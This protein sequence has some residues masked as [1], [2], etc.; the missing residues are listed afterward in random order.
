[1]STIAR[2]SNRQHE[3]TCAAVPE[4]D[5]L[6][7]FYGQMLSAQDFK[8]EQQYFREK[9][10]LHNRCL[11]GYGVVC[12]LS[13][14]AVKAHVECPSPSEEKRA[15]IE[16]KLVDVETRIEKIQ[17]QLKETLTPEEK[18]EY[19]RK[20]SEASAEREI[21][22][23]ELETLPSRPTPKRRTE[24]LVDVECGLA[25]DCCGNELLLR[26]TV[27][28]D[29]WCYL[30]EKAR[31]RIRDCGESTV[32]LSI[33]HCEEPINPVRPLLPERC[34]ASAKSNYGKTRDSIKFRVSL[35]P[36]PEDMR[37]EFCCTPCEH[38]CVLLASFLVTAEHG[39]VPDSVDNSVRR[40][41]GTYHP[42]TVQGISWSHAATYSTETAALV[43]GTSHSGTQSR[44]I[45]IRFSRPVRAE[46][47][48]DGV[49]D[50]WRV[51]G[52]PGI[53]GIITN[54]EGEYID[55]P[56]S[57]LLTSLRYRDKTSEMLNSED[58]VLI[59]VRTEFLLDQCC[60]PVAGA[61][62]GGRVPQISEYE[63]HAPVY[64]PEIT[65][66]VDPP[67]RFGSWTSG[68]VGGQFESWF[69]IE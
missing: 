10:K 35:D 32:Y 16:L 5:R 27:P 26:G 1:M 53:S 43:L 30:D 47:I 50:I 51:H 60:Q 54:I 55:K 13:V 48:T 36:P 68:P 69:Y 23:R 40:Y 49:V 2:S 6:N 65:E 58:R 21:L 11:H 44:G 57:G 14:V 22:L 46:T 18:I 8:S 17:G 41:L 56:K 62:V 37:C 20:L 61:H 4:F 67:H 63:E 15:E 9:L 39:V 25:I 7:Y 12:G 19:E 34:G 66:C 31:R 28:V 38:D 52:G 64:V 33:C 3:A 24:A 42:T 59:T 29:I 45:E